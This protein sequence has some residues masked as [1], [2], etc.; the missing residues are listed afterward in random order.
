VLK[1][2][3]INFKKTS[4]VEEDRVASSTF[5]SQRDVSLEFTAEKPGYYVIVPSSYL[6][7]ALF[8]FELSVYTEHA[9]DV[10]ELIKT[11]PSNT[12]PGAWKGTTAG[13]CANHS[14]WLNNPQYLVELDKEGTVTVTLEQIPAENP[15]CVG[16]YVFANK[17]SRVT[18]GRTNIVPKDL[19]NT[20]FCSREF[21]EKGTTHIIIPTTYD[22]V[23]RDF[24]ITVSSDA[25]I[26]KFMLV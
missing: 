8:R 6:P 7:S 20:V 13:G 1:A 18:G 23:D 2:N 25:T 5:T 11:L 10:S 4:F 9:C 12:L 26:Q 21:K 3:N 16:I 17:K 15:E 22:P 24:K 19:P 14:T